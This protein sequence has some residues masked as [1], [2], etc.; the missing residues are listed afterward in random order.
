MDPRMEPCQGHLS[1]PLARAMAWHPNGTQRSQGSS[2]S[3]LEGEDQQGGHDETESNPGKTPDGRRRS[4]WY[5]SS[6]ALNTFF[7][8]P[9]GEV[10]V[11]MFPRAGHTLRATLF[12]MPSIILAHFMSPPS[13]FMLPWMSR[14]CQ[15]PWPGGALL[16]HVLA[17]YPPESQLVLRPLQ[18]KHHGVK[19]GLG[20]VYREEGKSCMAKVPMPMSQ[21]RDHEI[22]VPPR[23]G[24]L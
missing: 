4:D 11:G 9:A 2:Q 23:R 13:S 7:R 10:N 17:T 1:A 21:Q 22:P 15:A 24:E 14:Y 3:E 6:A 19:E 18:T 12:I 20:V 5:Q 16:A 8:P